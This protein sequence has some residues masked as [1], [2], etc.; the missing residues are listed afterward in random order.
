[1]VVY[2]LVG[3]GGVVA[4]VTL[5]SYVTG[6][7]AM[8][9]LGLA[10]IVLTGLYLAERD[11]PAVRL[12]WVLVAG[13]VALA[14]FA[15]FAYGFG[16]AYASPDWQLDWAWA[17]PVVVA[18]AV[19][20]ASL[21]ARA[22]LV[23]FVAVLVLVAVPTYGVIPISTGLAPIYD[24]GLARAVEGIVAGD[25]DARWLVYGDYSTP[26]LVRAAG[27]DVFN[28]VR[29]PP[30]TETMRRLDPEG[31]NEW[32][33][34]RYAHITAVPTSSPVV[35]FGPVVTDGYVLTID[36][37]NEALAEAGSPLLRGASG[38]RA[39]LPRRRVQAPDERPAQRVRHLRAHR[40][41]AVARS[42]GSGARR[43]SGAG[44]V[45]AA[46]RATVPICKVA[47][48][49]TVPVDPATAMRG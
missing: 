33:W 45:K 4:R 49:A 24:K 31:K 16:R 18:L 38:G 9:G 43:G 28:G 46:G 48:R 23:Y 20:A 35:T 41:G 36:P 22:R 25:P 42:R 5:L 13:A 10:G 11:R 15:L 2:V 21:V 1:M 26:N 37:A 34:N 3:V 8:I 39:L 7:R 32:A 14:A 6:N 30:E 29:F 40:G 44:A 19:C 12:R 47:G 17:L 27:A